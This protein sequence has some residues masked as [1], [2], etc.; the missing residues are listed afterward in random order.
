MKTNRRFFLKG[1]AGAA[2]APAAGLWGEATT[3]KAAA[4][5]LS[6][7]MRFANRYDDTRLALKFPVVMDAIDY[8]GG[9]SALF[10]TLLTR[11]GLRPVKTNKTRHLYCV[12]SIDEALKA[13]ERDGGLVEFQPVVEGESGKVKWEEV[14]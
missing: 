14:A 2:L 1:C 9:D 3:P 10:E 6:R 7:L 12:A 8:C 13:A 11:Y 5:P 4:V